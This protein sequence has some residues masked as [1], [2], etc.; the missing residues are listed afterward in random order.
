LRPAGLQVGD[1]KTEYG[2]GF[3]HSLGGAT[4]TGGVSRNYRKDIMAAPGVRFT[5]QVG[6]TGPDAAAP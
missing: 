2:I 5:F 1:S 4:R 6:D 3:T